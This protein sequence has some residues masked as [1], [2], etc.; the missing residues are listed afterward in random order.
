MVGGFQLL[1]D[2]PEEGTDL[3]S[4]LEMDIDVLPHIHLAVLF[5]LTHVAACS[6]TLGEVITQIT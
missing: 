6:P 4:S 5:A 2:G 3:D 1:T